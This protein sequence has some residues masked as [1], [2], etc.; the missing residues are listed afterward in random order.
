[1]E[2]SKDQ[3]KSV[4]ALRRQASAASDEAPTKLLSFWG[5]S[6]LTFGG[7]HYDSPTALYKV[8]TPYNATFFS[9]AAST[10][11]RRAR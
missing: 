8:A 6:D 9:D 7:I 10:S 11:T 5:F 1:M 4:S 2:R 3:E